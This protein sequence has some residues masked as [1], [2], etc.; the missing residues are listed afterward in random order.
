MSEGRIDVHSHFLGGVVGEWFESSGYRATGGFR[1]PPWSSEAAVEFMQ[2]R[3]I[4]TQ[5]LSLPLAFGTMPDEPG[6]AARFAREV[7]EAYAD[8]IKECPGRFGA[9]AAVPM[10]TPDHALAEI[11]Y[12]LDTLG[13]D[14]VLLTSNAQGHYFGDPFHEPILAELARRKVPVFVHPEECPHID[15]LGFGRASAVVEY[16]F[17]TARTVTN[18]IYRGTFQRHPDLTLILAHCGGALP[19]LGWRISALSMLRGP[20]DADIDSDH[21]A[22]VLRRLYYDTALAGSSNSL[23][24]TL[25]VTTP[26]HLLFG[27]DWPAAPEPV[28]ADNID[29]LD[30]FEGLTSTQH[31]AINR[32]NA[33][34]L[35]P[36]LG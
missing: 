16:P 35:F 12:A 4:S 6:F 24:P 34:V 11:E 31:A 36:R 8:L 28:I 20:R 5:I 30:S 25:T 23:H 29:N 19:T 33:A 2:R 17:D 10:D 26:D 21:I 27:T 32:A 18:A 14:G 1:L 3:G 15:E 7:N 22:G 9:F 13:L